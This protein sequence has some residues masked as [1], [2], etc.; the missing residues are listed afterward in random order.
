[1]L[2]QG[3]TIGVMIDVN[4]DIEDAVAPPPP[5]PSFVIEEG[6][7]FDYLVSENGLDRIITE[8]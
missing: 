4:G 8:Y 6:S 5:V 7:L 1:M 2:N 3:L